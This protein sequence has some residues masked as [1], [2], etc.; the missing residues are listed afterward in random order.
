MIPG[1]IGGLQA[2]LAAEQ[3]DSGPLAARL[4]DP[5]VRLTM[6]E[7]QHLAAVIRPTRRGPRKRNEIGERSRSLKVARTVIRLSKGYSRGSVEGALKEA[8]EKHCCDAST[9][10]K[11]VAVAKRFWNGDWWKANCRLARKGK[12][13]KLL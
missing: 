12:G 3:G 1:D 13:H 6:W 4:L 5:A 11:H 10:K 8:G 7:R 9:V 2:V